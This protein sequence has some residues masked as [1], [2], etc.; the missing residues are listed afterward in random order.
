MDRGR[1][2]G[3]GTFLNTESMFGG[4]AEQYWRWSWGVWPGEAIDAS[5]LEREG[6]E[7]NIWSLVEKKAWE[8]QFDKSLIG[9][10]AKMLDLG[11]GAGKIV[12]LAIKRG[13]PAS[14]IVGLDLN[15]KLTNWCKEMWPEVTFVRGSCVNLVDLVGQ[16]GPFDLVTAHML[17]NHLDDDQYQM[18]LEQIFSIL[19]PGG[20]LIYMI[21][22]PYKT[23]DISEAVNLQSGMR[24]D[25]APWG[26]ITNHYF[27][28]HLEEHYRLIK[29]F[30]AIEYG[31]YSHSSFDENTVH[32]R[33]VLRSECKNPEKVK[34]LMVHA[35]D[36]K[37]QI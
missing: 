30:P 5:D 18:T 28:S 1:R 15:T 23:T 19:K 10:T 26:G 24:V 35:Q 36:M 29:L 11:C 20:D 27:R 37:P 9:K 4:Q 7:P 21:P 16:Y 13:V 34:R 25:E 17:F 33:Q 31:G 8:Y 3:V 32:L 22:S 14:G 2:I 6:R 12:D